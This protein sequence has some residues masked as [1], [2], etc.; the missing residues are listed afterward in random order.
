MVMVMDDLWNGN[1]KQ[2]ISTELEIIRSGLT[3]VLEIRKN[4]DEEVNQPCLCGR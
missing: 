3:T 2:K 4:K 1:L